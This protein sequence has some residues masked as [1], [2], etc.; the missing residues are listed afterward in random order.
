MAPAPAPL[1]FKTRAGPQWV[2]FASPQMAPTAPAPRSSLLSVQCNRS[3][4]SGGGGGAGG[5]R[6]QGPPPPPAG[7]VIIGGVPRLKA[8]VFLLVQVGGGGW[9]GELIL[10][11]KLDPRPPSIGQEA[12][13]EMVTLLGPQ[14]G[15][16]VP[17]ISSIEPTPAPQPHGCMHQLHVTH[18]CIPLGTTPVQFPS[19]LSPNGMSVNIFSLRNKK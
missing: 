9:G 15:V 19:P 17:K 5:F 2:R 14:L 6:I 12:K 16:S 4:F 11:W 10:T 7:I 1:S 13:L 18:G 8:F 3:L